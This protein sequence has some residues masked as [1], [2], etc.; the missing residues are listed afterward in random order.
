[1]ITP[2]QSAEASHHLDEVV[3]G[4]DVVDAAVVTTVTLASPH[5]TKS[6]PV[7]IS[8][9]RGT[10]SRSIKPSLQLRKPNIGGL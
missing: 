6:M 8:K 5:K 4:V 7:P 1:M 10:K 2:G 9:P 3:P